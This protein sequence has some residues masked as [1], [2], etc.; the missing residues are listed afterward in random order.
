VLAEYA[1]RLAGRPDLLE[2]ARQELA[3]R[4]LGCGCAP[5]LLC[6]RSILID[7]A[8]PPADPYLGGHAL[9][10]TVARP[11]ASL[12]LLPQALSPTVVHTRN[13]CTDHRGVLCV[14]ASHT[15]DE[16]GA[17]AATAAGFDTAWHTR[18]SGWLGAAVLLDVHPITPGCCGPLR[19][20]LPGWGQLP[21]PQR[22]RLYHWV[23][24]HGARLARPVF[25]HG[26]LGLRPVDW[27]IL[28]RADQGPRAV[29]R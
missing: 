27:A 10:V 12:I 26:F 24:Q 13:W 23:W 25:G 4:N 29:T 19:G 17:S 5:E 18:Q 28:I 6:H 9:A 7:L 14:I 21:H 20:Q 15:L 1:V 8:Q 22:R 11:W 16:H 3:G 2:A